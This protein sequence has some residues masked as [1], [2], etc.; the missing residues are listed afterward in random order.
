MTAN[1]EKQ[2]DIILPYVDC[3]DPEWLNDFRL[4]I[5]Q[6]YP[7]PFRFRSWGA[8]KYVLRAI[9][10]Y[11]PF[12]RNVILVVS[13]ESQVPVWLNRANV[14]IVYHK[15]FISEQ[16]LPVFNS[17]TIEDFLYNIPDVSEHFLYTNDDIFPINPLKF[18]DFFVEGK[19]R[20]K[21]THY[22]NHSND[23]LFSKQCRASI[24]F[25]S[26]ALGLGYMPPKEL[27]VPI[28]SITPML[29]SSVDEVGRL[30]KDKFDKTITPLRSSCNVNQYIYS[31]YNFVT[32]NYAEGS[33][34]CVYLEMNDDLVDIRFA[35]TRSNLKLICLNDS[36]K[37]RDY[38]KTKANLISILKQKYPDRSKFESL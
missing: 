15:E 10:K 8:L 36:N 28:H 3:D 25:I 26:S 14:R 27:L 6:E 21:F 23:T 11:I 17:C 2:V 9:D 12:V 38:E 1:I 24:D 30:C 7:S 18:E 22:V 20:L 19:P 37:I 33:C 32:D 35:F 29:K 16:F 4:A 34:N 13:R 31:D 5:N